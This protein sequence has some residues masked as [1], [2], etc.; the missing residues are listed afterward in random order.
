MLEFKFFKLFII[1]KSS[2]N[3]YSTKTISLK[4]SNN[5]TKLCIFAYSKKRLT[6]AH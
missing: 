3:S 1:L 4:Y 2:K 5:S 6:A